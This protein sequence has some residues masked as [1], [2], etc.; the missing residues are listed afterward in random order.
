MQDLVTVT[1]IVLKTIPVGEYDRHVCILT[2]ERGKITAYAKGA[3]KPNSRLVAAMNPFSFGEFK[4]FAGKT[5]YTLMEASISNYFEDLRKDYEAAYYGMYFMELA[6]YYTR[7]NNDERE[8]LKLLYQSLRALGSQKLDNQLVRLI[9]EMK[10]MVVNG[11]FPG[12]PND[13][14]LS[15]SAAY[16]IQFIASS[17]IEHLY[18]FTLSDKVFHELYELNAEYSK[19]YIDRKMNSLEVLETL[20]KKG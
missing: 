18:T 15:E 1:G 17:T 14:N 8:M 11:E 10:A 12:I 19:T 3:R 7:E 20:M 13:R 2:R 6:D 4:M 5:S 16:T 9:Y